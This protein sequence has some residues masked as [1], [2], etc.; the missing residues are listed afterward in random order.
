MARRERPHIPF[1]YFA[2]TMTGFEYI[3]AVLMMNWGMVPEGLECVRNT[4]AR[5]DGEKRNPWDEAEC[6]HHYARAM[7][8]WSAIV[9]L[10]GFSYNGA[11]AVRCGSCP[12]SPGTNSRCFWS[13]GTG[14]GTFSL[15]AERWP[16]L[17]LKVLAG[18]LACRSCEIAATGKT[19][20]VEIGGRV[21]RES[22]GTARRANRRNPSKNRLA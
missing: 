2:E 9:A 11:S 18:T 1:P 5:Y 20:S 8:S 19:A 16:E 10:S 6:G 17:A 3:A 12:E 13:T 22:G 15:R 4:R 7:A 14:W 21:G